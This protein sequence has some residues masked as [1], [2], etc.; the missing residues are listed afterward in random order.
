[1]YRGF[2]QIK[3]IMCFP[4]QKAGNFLILL[5]QEVVEADSVRWVRKTFN[6]FTDNRSINGYLIGLGRLVLLISQI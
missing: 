2:R 6:K 3:V 4:K 5:Q 1:M